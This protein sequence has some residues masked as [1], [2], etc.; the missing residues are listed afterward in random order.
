MKNKKI[1]L[2][3]LIVIV[4]IT[5]GVLCYLTYFKSDKPEEN[6]TIKTIE[7]YGYTLN[8]YSTD[9]YKIEFNTLNDILTKETV[10]YDEYAKQIS[11]LFIIDF[12]TLEN[13][14]SKNDIGGTEFIKPDIKDNFIEK[15]RS[16]FYK[17]LEVKE[18]RTQ[19]LPIVSEIT[20]VLAEKTLF[21]VKD[22]KENKEA[23]KVS[24]SWEYEED[25]DYEK[26]ADLYVVEES[27]KLYIVEMD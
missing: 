20:S 2:I 12:Y 27:N 6:K 14:L 9:L 19:T 8:N 13:K 25:L 15:S 18:G 22:T 5:I 16:T 7:K 10:D 1:I 26:E 4:S 24:I 3:T 17:Y 11:K 21:K 23:Y